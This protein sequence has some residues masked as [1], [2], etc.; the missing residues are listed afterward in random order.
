MTLER[1]PLTSLS[2]CCAVQRARLEAQVTAH[3]NRTEAE[4]AAATSEEAAR[5]VREDAYDVALDDDFLTA[6]EYGM[7]PTAGMVSGRLRRLAPVR[8]LC[9]TCTRVSAWISGKVW[10]VHPLGSSVMK[11][12]TSGAMQERT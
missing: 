12:S 1:Q 8:G 9:C 11:S 5:A 3:T 6:L 2:P 4:L 10:Y 7:P